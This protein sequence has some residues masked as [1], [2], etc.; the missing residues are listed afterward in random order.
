M[1]AQ[2]QSTSHREVFYE[3]LDADYL[4]PLR[5]DLGLETFFRHTL[6]FGI[7]YEKIKALII[8]ATSTENYT[9]DTDS[10]RKY[11]QYFRLVDGVVHWKPTNKPIIRFDHLYDVISESHR[12]RHK[13]L[14]GTWSDLTS[15]YEKQT[16]TV[17][18][19]FVETCPG[20][21][22]SPTKPNNRKNKKNAEN[23]PPLPRNQRRCW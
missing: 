18:E 8:K 12:G 2:A 3:R 15:K 17:V 13:D 16:R 5:R 19:I 22:E 9:P 20:C 6:D 21:Q 4:V 1:M 11:L 14:E 23:R 10:E 7:A